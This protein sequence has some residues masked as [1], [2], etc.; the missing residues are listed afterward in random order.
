M[1]GRFFPNLS[2]YLMMVSTELDTVAHRWSMGI[3]FLAC[4][5]ACSSVHVPS[6][7]ARYRARDARE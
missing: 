3:S 5:V 7:V 4:S 1:N 6:S 2:R